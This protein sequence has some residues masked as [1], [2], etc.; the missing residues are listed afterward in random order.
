MDRQTL[1]SA[2]SRITTQF[3]LNQEQYG[4]L[5]LAFGWSFAAGSLVFGLLA[6]AFP[7][8]LLYPLILAAWSLCGIATGFAEGYGGLLVCRG[9]LGFFEAGHWPCALKT[10][11]RL[12]D[13]G[14]RAMGNS[15]LQ[16]GTSIGA[17]IT[18]LVMRMMMTSELSSWRFAFI[19]VGAVGL[20]WVVVW[21][22]VVRK[23]DLTTS[24][25]QAGVASHAS[26]SATVS[27]LFRDTRFW[28]VAWVIV[29]INTCWQVLRAWLPKFLQEGRGYLEQDALTFTSAYYLASD[30]GCL[31]AGAVSLWLI[32]KGVT[33]HRSRA[34]VFLGC[35]LLTTVTSVSAILPKGPLLLF[36]LLLAGAGALGV[37]PCYYAFTQELSSQRQ[38][39]V[40]G[41][42]GVFAWAFSSP[43]HKLFGW[44]IDRTDSFNLGIAVAGWLPLCAFLGLW[45][46]WPENRTQKIAP[47]V[48]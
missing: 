20:L 2:A 27:M 1:A 25:P 46:F 14:D 6:D 13:P 31:G 9:L 34:Y 42:T 32:K 18:P 23:H 16:S 3:Q 28:I 15:V 36:T 30:V 4:D 22:L 45:F 10:T 48:G 40:S 26:I 41:L 12:L 35:A 47:T 19:C 29:C 24:Q 7:V 5:E 21:F 44:L 43:A 8:R 38:G 17:I 39:L 37:F 33:V 11:Q